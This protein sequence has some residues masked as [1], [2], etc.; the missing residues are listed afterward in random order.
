MAPFLLGSD[1]FHERENQ[2]LPAYARRLD[3][4]ASAALFSPRLQNARKKKNASRTRAVVS[5]DLYIYQSSSSER[6]CSL[7]LVCHICSFPVHPRE[8]LLANR[9]GLCCWRESFRR[10][11]QKALLVIG[12]SRVRGAL[13]PT[14]ARRDLRGG[15]QGFEAL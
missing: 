5:K 1:A 15:A 6:S 8:M 11:A 9:E 4:G 12:R 3:G 10:K 2:T 7:F 13:G 14:R